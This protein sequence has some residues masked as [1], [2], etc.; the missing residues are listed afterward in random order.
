MCAIGRQ[1]PLDVCYRDFDVYTLR[2]TIA[3]SDFD[4]DAKEIVVEGEFSVSTS[5]SSQVKAW[6][7][8]PMDVLAKLP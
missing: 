7:D 1:E 4:K 6:L 8:I 2:R 3:K 5:C